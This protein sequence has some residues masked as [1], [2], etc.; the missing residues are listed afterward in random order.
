MLD[1][2][3]NIIFPP[4]CIGCQKLGSTICLK[5]L[6]DFIPTQRDTCLYCFYNSKMG[7]THDRCRK[8]YGLDGVLS[9]V[10]Y[11]NIAKKFIS[12]I[13]YRMAYGYF[14]KILNKLPVFWFEKLTEFTEGNKDWFLQPIPLYSKKK[15]LRGFNQADLVASYFAKITKLKQIDIL[16]RTKDAPPQARTH[17]KKE[18]EEN[19]KGAFA[20]NKKKPIPSKIILVDDIYT[21]ASTAK[22]AAKTLK[23]AG[24]KQV[25]LFTLAHGR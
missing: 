24:I 12:Q 18:R 20:V 8:K 5:C 7:Q 21:S 11:N 17:S 14:E 2:I 1:N 25:Y 15:N 6:K 22:E 3:L 13:K 4:V 23:K 10:L 19:I 9:I 16:K